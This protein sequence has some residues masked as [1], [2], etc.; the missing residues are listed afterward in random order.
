MG[1]YNVTLGSINNT[2]AG[3]TDGYQNYSCTLGTTL[4][5]GQAYP[6]SITTNANVDENVRVWLDWNNNGAFDPSTELVFSSNGA[7]VHTG[8][9]VAVPPGAVTG[10]PLRLRV[11]ADGATVSLPTPCST[12]QYS[13]VEDYSVTL[14]ATAQ[15]PGLAFSIGVAQS[16]AGTFAFRDQ[17]SRQP[18]SWRWTFGDGTSSAQQHP[19]HTYAQPGTYT[20]Q[21]RA[22]N[23]IGCDSSQQQLTFFASYPALASCQPTTLSYC[24]NYGITRFDFGDLTQT[25]ADG[26]A[27][28]E[29]YSCARRATVAQ[30]QVVPLHITTAQPQDT[31]VYLDANNDG[32]FAAGELLYQALNRP[33]PQDFVTVPRTTLTNQPLRLRVIS[34]AVGTANGATSPCAARTSGQVEDYTVVVTP[35][36]CP[37]TVQAGQVTHVYSMGAN[38][39]LFANTVATALLLTGYSPGAAVQW[40]RSRSTAPAVWQA[41]PGAVRPIRFYA[42][43][44]TAPDSLYRAAI[45]CGGTTVY[46]ASVSTTHPRVQLGTD[47]C[48]GDYIRRVALTGTLLDNPSTCNNTQAQGYRLL[49]PTRP[50][51]TATV[52]RGETYQLLVST[53]RSSRVAV[54]VGVPGQPM[55]SVQDVIT[56]PNGTPTSLTLFLDSLQVPATAPVL[57]LRLR[58]VD[59]TQYAYPIATRT[60]TYNESLYDGETEDYVL[61]VAPFACATTPVTAGLLTAPTAPQCAR[62]NF[63]LHLAG[64]TPGTSLQWQSSPDSLTWQNIASMSRTVLTTRLQATT[65]YRVRAQGCSGLAVTTPVVGV[66]LLP[67]ADCYCPLSTATVPATAPVI[68]RVQLLG[69]RLDNAS[70]ATTGGPRRVRYAPTTPSQTAE[71]VRGAT[72]TLA[73]TVAN[74][75]ATGASVHAAAWLDLDRNGAY[76]SLEWV[77]LLRTPA[78][79]GSIVYQATLPVAASAQLGTTALRVRVGNNVSY[80]PNLACEVGTGA[81]QGEIEDY[82]LTIIAPPCGATL[83]AGSI[84]PV[85][86]PNGRTRLRSV[87]YTLGTDLQCTLPDSVGQ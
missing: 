78:A 29:D 70:P 4:N 55:W 52:M 32:L 25:S 40:E 54:F 67:L 82:T 1:I 34:D 23:A 44:A 43:R 62:D 16:C 31:W 26:Q 63:T 74:T 22:C 53:L 48:T 81:G 73:L 56:A 37:A 85:S 66:H 3:T 65:Y 28:Y 15:V 64:S 2:T 72:Y 57:L 86:A 71:V 13:Q 24:C 50:T 61:R 38:G 83:T 77:H 87:A 75:P 59:P 68:A 35:S 6:I 42:R 33:S 21:L 36:P 10:L 18:T 11:A 39:S 58:C 27:G 12:P 14:Q 47:G 20:V 69:T 46:T 30:S 5:T 7:R 49:D 79:N 41:L 76:D 51:Q 60:I 84:T 45:T 8:L 80:R 19:A 17:S 9:T